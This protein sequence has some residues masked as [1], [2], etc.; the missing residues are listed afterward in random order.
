MAWLALV[1]A[2]N[3]QG[4]QPGPEHQRLKELEGTWDAVVKLAEGESKGTMT[5]K[6]DLGGMWLT[7]EFRG[8]LAGTKFHGKGFDGYD[9]IKK[10]YVGIWV[11]SMSSSPVVTEGTFD[12][13]GKVL[14]MTGEG[15]G[16]DGSP[17]KYK[18]TT[19]HK[20]KDLLVFTMFAPGPDGKD[21]AMMTITYTR[22]KA[23]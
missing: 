2:A 15:P 14:T 12:K 4:P 3:A 5:Y 6:I 9:P 8:E 7:S 22:R 11:D 16:P 13:E 10:K 20:T 1:A 23:G 18:L 19:E 21:M 17:M